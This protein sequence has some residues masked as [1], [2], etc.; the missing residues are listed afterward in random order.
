MK[1][2]VSY[3]NNP[4]PNRQWDYEAN[5][6]GSL[7][8]T[9]GRSPKEAVAKLSELLGKELEYDGMVFYF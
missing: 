5:I 1:V 3:T 8:K 2:V 7:T 4:T 9:L 6:E